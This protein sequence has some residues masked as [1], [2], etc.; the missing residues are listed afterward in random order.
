MP[1]L[2]DRN[3]QIPNGFKF[4]QPETKWRSQPWQ[5]FDMIVRSLIAH[6]QGQPF[7]LQKHGWSIDPHVVANEVDAYNALLCQQ[8]GWHQYVTEG[9]AASVAPPKSNPLPLLQKLKRAAGVGAGVKPLVEWLASGAEAVP[10]PTSN[11]RARIC[12]DCPQNGHGDFTKWFTMP[13]TEAIRA[14]LNRRR[15]FNLTTPYDTRLGVCEACLCP[16]KLKVHMPI[17]IIRSKMDPDTRATLD[18][19]CWINNER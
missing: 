5:S 11:E 12:S 2:L 8:M 18:P 17:D 4:Y 13:V 1:R 16:L 15:D 9:G 3:K 19:R 6:R 14:E 7:L 10:L